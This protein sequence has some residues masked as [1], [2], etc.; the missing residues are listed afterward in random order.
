[1][2]RKLVQDNRKLELPVDRF[3]PADEVVEGRGVEMNG[4]KVRSRVRG[5]EFQEF[6]MISWESTTRS[7]LAYTEPIDVECHSRRGELDV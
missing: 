4:E 2:H 1:M 5:Y 3:D 7:C 6:L